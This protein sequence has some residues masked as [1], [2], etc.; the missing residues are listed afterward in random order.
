M[1]DDLLLQ[2]Q[3]LKE[4]KSAIEKRIKDV[5]SALADVEYDDYVLPNGYVA[6]VAPNVRFNAA[7]AKKNLD[8]DT[9]ATICKP[10]PDA[11]LA[12]ALL[13][14]DYYKC[15][16]VSGTKITFKEAN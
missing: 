12:K 5:E 1:S 3:A 13:E 6:V 16:S 2:L 8:P 11:A 15:Q 10:K 14:E 4:E 7:T 9:F